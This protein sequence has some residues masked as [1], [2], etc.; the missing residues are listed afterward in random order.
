MNAVTL[1]EQA[2]FS[3]R[4]EFF[5]RAV[6]DTQQTI[7]FIDTKA[8]FC[9]TLL[10]GM[11]AVSLEHPPTGFLV[12]HILFPIF[13]LTIACSVMA[14]MRVIFPTIIPHGSVR[15]PAT[16]KFFIGHKKAH[17]WVR[18]TI[19]NPRSNILSEDHATYLESL[20]AAND[21]ALLD[22]MSETVVALSFIRQIKSDRLHFAMYSLAA[23][24]L[25][26][27]AIAIAQL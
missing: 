7:R 17:H 5:Y 24:I 18:H 10:S 12:R 25:L 6:E 21:T 16:P 23:A 15:P 9:V 3:S 22:S 11:V 26:F 8:A 19:R 4:L 1:E 14:S 2:E 27:V 13:I 20:H